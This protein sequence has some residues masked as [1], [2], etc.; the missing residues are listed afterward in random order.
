MFH[1][2]IEKNTLENTYYRKVIFTGDHIQ[3]VLMSLKPNEIIDR[4][5]HEKNDQFIRI[6]KGKCKVNITNEKNL[7]IESFNLKKD[8]I[9]IIPA[10]TYHEIINIG[11]ND[12][13]L[14]TI[15]GPPD[16]EKECMQLTKEQTG[17]GYKYMKYVNKIKKLKNAN[18]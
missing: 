14:Y 15:Y 11:N 18:I 3:L 16:H 7:L 5:I 8:N 9:V 10:M 13:K 17:C 2:N 12:L 1:T 6:E 4:E